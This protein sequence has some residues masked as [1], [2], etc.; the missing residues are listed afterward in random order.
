M[1]LSSDLVPAVLTLYKGANKDTH[2]TNN[3]LPEHHNSHLK[4]V[5]LYLKLQRNWRSAWTRSRNDK[6]Y[7]SKKIK[8][9]LDQQ[10][11]LELVAANKVPE[12]LLVELLVAAQVFA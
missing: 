1:S 11:V 4:T 12:N 6:E 7:I 2:I 8:T 9:N 3:S 5:F 10:Q